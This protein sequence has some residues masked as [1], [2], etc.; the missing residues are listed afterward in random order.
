MLVILLLSEAD[1]S[2]LISMADGVRLVEQAL[3]QHAAGASLVMPRVSAD[4]PGTGGAFRVMS[5]VLPEIGFFGLKTLTGYPGRRKPN[6]TYFALLLFGCESGALRA[7]VAAGRLTG[8]R[9]GAATGVAAKYMSRPDSRVLG[10]FGAGVQARYQVAALAEVR[11]LEEIRVFD[12]DA[13]KAEAFA[14]EVHVDLKI[15]AHAVSSPRDAVAGCD[16]VVSVTASKEPVFDGNWLEPG[17]HVSGVGSNSP[18]KCE[19][20]LAT[21]QR[22]R[23]V[24]DFKDQVL[25]EAGDYKAALKTGA[26]DEPPIYAELGDIVSGKKPGRLNDG[27]ITLFKSVGMAIE[28]IAT[29]SFAYQRALEAGVGMRLDLEGTSLQL[30]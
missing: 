29:A 14:R 27:E 12:I 13:R 23:I 10:I 21:F 11:P 22:S 9:T 17:T 18:G 24:V 4:L 16:L 5:A 8:I 7:V 30:V 15:P 20:D 26:L 19:L 1:V 28:D 6:E 3:H 25:Q 2:S